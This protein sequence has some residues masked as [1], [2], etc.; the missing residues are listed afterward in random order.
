LGNSA[1]DW[2]GLFLLK[3]VLCFCLSKNK[4]KQKHESV[5]EQAKTAQQLKQKRSFSYSCFCLVLLKQNHAKRSFLSYALFLLK[6][7]HNMQASKQAGKH[8]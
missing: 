3:Q 2:C 7:K 1:F 8:A 5:A 6:Q 4:L